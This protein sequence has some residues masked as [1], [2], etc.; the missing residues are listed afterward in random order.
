MNINPFIIFIINILDLY[1]FGLLIFVLLT[2][3]VHFNIINPYQ[4]FV[5]KLM[6][7]LIQLMEP[8]LRYIRKI[9]PPIAGV[10]IS[11]I[12]FILIIQL[13]KNILLTYF[14]K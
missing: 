11:S 9:I 2:W 14:H 6:K 3:L 4:P 10:D 1:N 13:L 8:V 12:V 7:F 5:R